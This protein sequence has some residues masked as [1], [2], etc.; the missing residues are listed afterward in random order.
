MKDFCSVESSIF[1]TKID[2]VH[3]LTG[4]VI[5]TQRIPNSDQNVSAAIV[6]DPKEKKAFVKVDDSR[7]SSAVFQEAVSLADKG[8][9]LSEVLV[10][11]QISYKT[12]S[13]PTDVFEG[14]RKIGQVTRN[15][16]TVSHKDSALFEMRKRTSTVPGLE[17]G[18]TRNAL[19]RGQIASAIDYN[20]TVAIGHFQNMASSKFV[21]GVA[22][23][24]AWTDRGLKVTEISADFYYGN[25]EDAMKK[26]GK[27]AGGLV[28][29]FTSTTLAV[30]GT[31][32]LVAAGVITAPLAIPVF[33]V[34]VAVGSLATEKMFEYEGELLFTKL[35]HW[36]NQIIEREKGRSIE[37]TELSEDF[38]KVSLNPF[39]Y[40]LESETV[41]A[42]I[43]RK[44][45]TV[46]T[47]KLSDL[48]N[49]L[50]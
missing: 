17:S 1:V 46:E 4:E 27:L 15:R 6:V 33:L 29:D 47:V 38:R 19:G 37:S 25:N 11:S 20:S 36:S 48:G 43:K 28:S 23:P 50:D 18:I 7:V 16:I 26:S 9:S 34:L 10:K 22:R 2:Y 21:R 44:D 35:Y 40:K 30:A 42:T 39:K 32:M 5:W 13:S 41:I 45:G 24:I 14:G 31:G 8:K 12:H 49:G 3:Y